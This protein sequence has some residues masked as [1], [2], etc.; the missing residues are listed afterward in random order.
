MYLVRPLFRERLQ[1]FREQLLEEVHR[2]LMKIR[3]AAFERPHF[4]GLY[5]EEARE[6]G[7]K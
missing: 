1:D 6:Q 3:S 4:S 7:K 2:A 5:R